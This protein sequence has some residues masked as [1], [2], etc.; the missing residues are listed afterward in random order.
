[1]TE[2]QE[3]NLMLHSGANAEIVRFFGFVLILEMVYVY[4][5]IFIIFIYI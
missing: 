3:T 4:Y 2:T 1:M 5:I